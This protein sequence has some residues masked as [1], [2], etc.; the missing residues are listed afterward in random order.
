MQVDVV[1][2]SS[3]RLPRPPRLLQSREEAASCTSIGHF[4]DD[5]E[6]QLN[7]LK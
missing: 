7:V 3:P 5:S 6:N 2:M 4:V 1:A